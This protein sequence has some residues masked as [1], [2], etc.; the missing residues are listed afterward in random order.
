[1]DVTNLDQIEHAINSTLRH[2]S[3]IDVL[4]N[5]AGFGITGASEAYTEDEVRRQLETNLY[6]AIAITRRIIPIMREQH[7]GRI[8]QLVHWGAV[9]EMQAYLYTTLPNSGSLGIARLFPKS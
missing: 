3:R 1:M 7:S 6:G 2:F 5:N 9:L 4:V 8:L